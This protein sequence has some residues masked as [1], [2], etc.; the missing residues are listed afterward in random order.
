MLPPNITSAE[1]GC[2]AQPSPSTQIAPVP[3][4]TSGPACARVL[5]SRIMP[6]PNQDARIVGHSAAADLP[7]PGNQFAGGGFRN[8]EEKSIGIQAN[9]QTFACSSSLS[10]AIA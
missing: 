1:G 7:S 2:D 10:M 3:A 9:L 8:D 4:T 6:T 5:R